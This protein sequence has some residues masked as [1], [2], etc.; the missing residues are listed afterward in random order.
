MAQRA[1]HGDIASKRYIS[2][3]RK[4]AS[5]SRR[6]GERADGMKNA[7]MARNAKLKA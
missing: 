4:A 7:E 1:T 3:Q 6:R 5:R 2:L